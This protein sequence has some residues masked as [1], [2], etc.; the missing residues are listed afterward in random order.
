MH[1]DPFIFFLY[2]LFFFSLSS[3]RPWFIN[4]DPFISLKR[5][6]EASG[7]SS[8]TFHDFLKRSY[9]GNA[10]PKSKNENYQKMYWFL[11]KVALWKF[12]SGRLG[13]QGYFVVARLPGIW[14]WKLNK[15][16]PFLF[17]AALSKFTSGR[18]RDHGYFVD[19]RLLTN[20]FIL[21]TV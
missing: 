9:K 18:F 19:A 16:D 12:T 15:W 2:L 14:K 7:G 4:L 11:F 20:L 3:C 5:L 10:S 13:D 17:N 1:L 6:Q 21:Y 8:I